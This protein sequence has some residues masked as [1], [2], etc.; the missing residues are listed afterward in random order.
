MNEMKKMTKAFPFFLLT[1]LLITGCLKDPPLNPE[2]GLPDLQ[3][4]S[5][6]ILPAVIPAAEYTDMC[7][8]TG[9]TGFAVSGEGDIIRTT[10]SGL[11]WINL[12]YQAHAYLHRIQFVNGSTGFIIGGADTLPSGFLLKTTDAGLSWQRIVLNTPVSGAPAALY[13]LDANTGFIA[14]K[15]FLRR[16]TDGGNT[17]TDIPGTG[18]EDFTDVKFM[19]NL[20]GYATARSG[21]YYKT[22]NGG[23]SWQP[24]QIITSIQLGEIV[25]APSKMFVRVGT[26]TLADLETGQHAFIFPSNVFRMLFLSESAALGIGQHY[27]MGF[28]PYGDILI[29]NSRWATSKAKRFEP[30]QA[31]NFRA[32]A[33]A[34]EHKL[35]MLGTGLLQTTVVQLKY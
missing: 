1:A 12:P 9:Q 19:D 20:K 35:V 30:G 18:A 32:I 3:I 14:G 6:K 24:A 21:R 11:H 7:F 31:V 26:S 28:W 29:T 4:D 17:W 33:K 2:P 15:Q 5:L 22:T 10:D 13:F 34:T 27:E 23:N 16:T 8:V 25:A